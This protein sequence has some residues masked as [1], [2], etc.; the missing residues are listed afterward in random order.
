M[1]ARIE[2]DVNHD[3][4]VELM[5]F[6][7]VSMAF[8]STPIDP[9]WNPHADLNGDGIIELMDFWIMSRHFGETW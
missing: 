7:I 2:G 5:D 1:R 6:Y 4:I 3:G 9:N 8:S